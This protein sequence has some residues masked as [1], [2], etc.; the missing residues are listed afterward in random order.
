MTYGNRGYDDQPSYGPPSDDTP[1]G[2]QTAGIYA[3]YGWEGPEPDPYPQ[4]IYEPQEA[5]TEPLAASTPA[6]VPR[7]HRR[8][9]KGGLG[10]LAGVLAVLLFLG[11]GIAAYFLI[12]SKKPTNTA[13]PAPTGSGTPAVGD[14]RDISS[15]AV[16][17]T[18]LTEAELFPTTTITVEGRAYAIQKTQSLTDCRLAVTGELSSDYAQLGCNQIVRATV[19]SPDKAFIATVGVF[20]FPDQAAAISAKNNTKTALGAGKGAIAGWSVGGNTD[21][22]TRAETYL[23]WVPAGHYLAYCV[24]AYADG[25]KPNPDNPAVQQMLADTAEI[26]LKGQ[27][28]KRL[29]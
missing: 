9:S 20:N 29:G 25:T 23:S 22:I 10:V 7:T 2:H 12:D 27:L 15:Q 18:L 5:S 17:P 6:S 16:D 13:I 21:V 8:S 28:K 14:M 1:V 19:L 3:P 26:Y 4:P 11:F 24:L